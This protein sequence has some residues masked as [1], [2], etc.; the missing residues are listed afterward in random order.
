MWKLIGRSLN[1]EKELVESVPRDS[2]C[3]VQRF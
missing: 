3:E 1:T 2:G